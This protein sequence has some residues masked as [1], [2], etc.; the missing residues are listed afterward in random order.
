M[1]IKICYIGG[2]SRGWTRKFMGD[3]ALQKSFYGTVVLYDIDTGAAEDN[4]ILGNKISAMDAAKSK[5]K[6][7]VAKDLKQAL[8]EVD[9][10]IMSIL[11]GTFEEM[12]SDVHSGERY[13]IYQPVGDSVGIGGII[14]AM[15]TIPIYEE[16]ANAISK[17]CPNAFVI[18]FTNPLTLCTATLY[19]VFKGIKAFGC[20]HEVFSTQELLAKIVEEKCGEKN[21]SRKEVDIDVNGVNH[22][23]WITRCKIRGIE[24][25]SLYKEYI[26]ENFDKLMQRPFTDE[27]KVGAGG[28]RDLVKMDLFKRYGQVAAAGDRHLV[29]FLNNTWYLNDTETIEKYK[30]C[31]TPISWRKENQAE[32]LK[33]TQ[34]LLRGERKLE[35]KYSGEEFVELMEGLLGIRDFIS[36][37]NLPNKG[38]SSYAPLGAIVETNAIFSKGKI[39]PI[40][41]V[42]LNDSVSAMVLKILNNQQN[43]LNAIRKRD[44]NAVFNCFMQEPMAC[45]LSLSD[46]E[47]LF[48]YMV[49]STKKYLNDWKI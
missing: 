45:K 13:G 1:E 30:F 27:E 10:V 9:F 46:G 31:L 37:V 16:Y 49:E 23:T 32:R 22:F 5:W 2:G 12:Y 4:A 29:E 48:S 47:K 11:P 44:I 42:P 43:T 14:R 40:E 38:Q 19:D 33:V 41:G 20:C 7:F 18:N 21:I 8:T 15:R 6:Y 3:I 36:N 17:Y 39:T 24:A 35:I 28:S 34:M 25:I 26:E